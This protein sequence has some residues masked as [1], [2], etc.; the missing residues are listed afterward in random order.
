MS[1]LRGAVLSLFSS[2]HGRV[3]VDDSC[4]SFLSLMI[5]H[6]SLMRYRVKSMNLF[7]FKYV[8]YG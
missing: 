3:F 5:V 8:E 2:L 7:S 6:I 1:E 4:V